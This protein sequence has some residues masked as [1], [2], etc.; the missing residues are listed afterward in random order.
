MG[1][2]RAQVSD[3]ARPEERGRQA[4]AGSF[5]A[6]QPLDASGDP[7]TRAGLQSSRARDPPLPT[8][9]RPCDG[10]TGW[11]HVSPREGRP[12]QSSHVDPGC[13]SLLTKGPG[14]GR[15]LGAP[16]RLGVQLFTSSPKVGPEQGRAQLDR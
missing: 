10:R 12:P 8:G 13:H 1:R 7:E 5:P 3:Q 15:D 4:G 14:K 6:T 16:L 2:A 9:P 11:G